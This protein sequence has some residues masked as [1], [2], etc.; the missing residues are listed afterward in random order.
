L[1][2]SCRYAAVTVTL[3][4]FINVEL[5]SYRYLL[6]YVHYHFN[7]HLACTLQSRYP[8]DTNKADS[9]MMSILKRMDERLTAAEKARNDGT[10]NDGSTVMSN[11]D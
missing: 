9:D 7:A 10:P 4:L 3:V 5:T 8:T 2:K 1:E 6:S 11:M